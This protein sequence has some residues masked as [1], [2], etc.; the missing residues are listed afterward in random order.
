MKMTALLFLFFSITANAQLTTVPYVDV[1]Q[2]LGIW[3]QVAGNPQPFD[4]DCFCSRQQLSLRSDGNVD[5]Y[6]TCNKGASNGPLSEIRGVAT[7][8]DP[9]SN[10]KFEVDFGLPFKGN[11]WIIALDSNYQYAVV[12]DPTK[13]SLFVL[14][15]TPTLDPILYQQALS[16]AEKQVSL[17]KLTTMNQNSCQYPLVREAS[18]FPNPPLDVAHPGSKIYS[19]TFQ[20]QKA[21]CQK[22]NVDVFLPNPNNPQ[23]KFPVIVLGHGQALGLANYQ[24]TFEHLAKKGVAVVFPQYSTGFFDQDWQRM[25]TDYALMAD[26]AVKQFQAQLMTNEIIFSGHSKG[27]YVASVAAGLVEKLN[28]SFDLKHTLLFAAAG[29]DQKTLPQIPASSALTVVYSDADTIVEKKFS[30]EIFNKSGASKKQFILLK[31]YSNIKADHFWPLTK[32]SAFGGGNEGP[33]H[34]YSLWKWL[35]AAAEDLKSGSPFTHPYLYGSLT[36]DKGLSE[37][38]DDLKK[39]GF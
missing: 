11:Y 14:S 2:Y 24:A 29:A 18:D 16:E 7:S 21:T 26:C 5:V 38:Q 10:S 28:V 15:K 27:A 4:S 31:S 9:V 13:R 22:R 25:G 12:S 23:E 39:I 33:L 3:Y 17:D 1:N 37:V 6:N 30:D 19:H 36:T 34:Y 8:L 20:K 32:G 35:G